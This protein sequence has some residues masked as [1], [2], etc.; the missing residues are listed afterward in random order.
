MTEPETIKT[1]LLRQI[2]ASVRWT[3]CVTMAANMGSTTFLELGA[4]KVL[5]GLLKQIDPNLTAVYV[6]KIPRKI[7]SFNNFLGPFLM[8]LI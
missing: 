7:Y 1:L 5:S 2:T 3:D 6:K 8:V 4:G